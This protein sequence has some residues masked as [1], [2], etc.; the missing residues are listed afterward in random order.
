MDNLLECSISLVYT[1]LIITCS[2]IL[3][4]L[5]ML[6]NGVSMLVIFDKF[7]WYIMELFIICNICDMNIG[8]IANDDLIIGDNDI[9]IILVL[10][11]L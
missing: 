5:D 4:L 11:V 8:L 6:M 2:M 7:T 3:Y 9:I 1:S 10:N